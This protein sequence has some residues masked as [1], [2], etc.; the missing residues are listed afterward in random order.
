M[1]NNRSEAVNRIVL[2]NGKKLSDDY[3]E[4]LNSI[5]DAFKNEPDFEKREELLKKLYIELNIIADE[6]MIFRNK[7]FLE[8]QRTKHYN[9]EIQK[10]KS[11][12]NEQYT[13]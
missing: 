3:Q 10:R 4:M 6:Q 2:N 7:V 8:V 9:E 1:H 11:D 12:N 13:N 5:F